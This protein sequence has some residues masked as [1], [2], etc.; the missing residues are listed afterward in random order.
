[1]KR[2]AICLAPLF[3]F[4]LVSVMGAQRAADTSKV[5]GSWEMTSEGPQG[6]VAQTITIEQDGSKIKGTIKG[7]RGEA[8]FDGAIDGNKISFTVK[9]QTPNGEI[10]IE[11][12][13][14]VED[15]SIKGTMK[16]PRGERPWTAKRSK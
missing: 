16:T 7:A 4:A 3:A 15:D 14:T 1:M 12:S 5:A 10:T 6:T 13:G 2:T 9:R 11:Y 8:P